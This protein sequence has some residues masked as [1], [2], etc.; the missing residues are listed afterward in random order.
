MKASFRLKTVLWHALKRG[1]FAV[2]RSIRDGATVRVVEDLFA[3]GPRRITSA[4][5]AR[6]W[7]AMWRRDGV[8]FLVETRRLDDARKWLRE[9][10][11][12]RH[13]G[14]GYGQPPMRCGESVDLDTLFYRG[15]CGWTDPDNDERNGY[16][17]KH[18]RAKD[19]AEPGACFSWTCPIAY[20][21]LGCE[22]CGE[23][24]DDCACEGGFRR[25]EENPDMVLRDRPRYALAGNVRI[26]T[27][28]RAS[29][30]AADVLHLLH[31]LD[32]AEKHVQRWQRRNY[33]TS[34]GDDAYSKE[35]RIGWTVRGSVWTPMTDARRLPVIR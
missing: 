24:K 29:D 5:R 34:K 14:W 20:E 32:A 25:Y 15:T 31:L 21:D 3:R 28:I 1:A 12:V 9:N 8:T 17:C 22:E 18:P 6:L 19:S 27:T 4:R 2:L 10:A 30:D 23:E 26:G 7:D 13:F 33:S 11:S 16:G 35:H